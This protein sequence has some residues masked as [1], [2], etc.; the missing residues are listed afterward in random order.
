MMLRA[1]NDSHLKSALAACQREFPGF[2]ARFNNPKTLEFTR[3]EPVCKAWEE[4]YFGTFAKF[5]EALRANV[6]SGGRPDPFVQLSIDHHNLHRLMEVLRLELGDRQMGDGRI[7][8][9]LVD[10]TSGWHQLD[11]RLTD[12]SG[13]PSPN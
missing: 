7:P 8:E 11:R 4:Y 5:D 13:A 10:L 6:M 12:V 3:M 9:R 2:I 1:A